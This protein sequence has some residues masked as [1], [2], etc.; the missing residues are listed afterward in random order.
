[1]AEIRGYHHVSLSVS[2]L[3][4]STEWYRQVLGFEV[5]A[6]VE[7]DGFRR[8]RMRVPGSGL[9]LTLTAHDQPLGGAFDE[10]RAGLDHVAFDIGSI[11]AVEELKGRLEQVGAEHSVVKHLSNGRA[12]ITL[13]DPDNIQLEV[14]GDTIDPG[15]TT[16]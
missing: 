2:D 10:H 9:T 12:M 6:E 1:M 4:K 15:P 5:D 14:F 16:G 13:R 11:V 7:G 3:P 8:T